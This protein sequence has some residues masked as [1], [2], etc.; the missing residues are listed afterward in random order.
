MKIDHTPY[1]DAIL[2]GKSIGSQAKLAG[3]NVNTLRRL[4]VVHP[5]YDN[6]KAN[7]QLHSKG[8]PEVTP[9]Y[10]HEAVDEAVAEVALGALVVP[11]AAKYGIPFASLHKLFKKAHPEISLRHRD[12]NPEQVAEIKL[13]NAR[14]ALK[15][16]A[17]KLKLLESAAK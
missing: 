4:L 11:T 9:D 12:K 16:A 3:V 6:A 14:K 8:L 7:G 15:R 13:D 17:K 10:T 2:G 1:I 5:D